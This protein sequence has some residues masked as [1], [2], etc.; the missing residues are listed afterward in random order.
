MRRVYL[1]ILAGCLLGLNANAQQ[2]QE[3]ETIPFQMVEQKPSFNGGDTKAFTEWV[4]SH[5]VYPESEK[6]NGTEGRVTLSITIGADGSIKDVSVIRGTGTE[7]DKEAV[8]VVSSSP[9]WAPGRQK[10]V[11]VNVSFM[12]PVMF[13]LPKPSS[14]NTASSNSESQIKEK[15]QEA[16]HS[17]STNNDWPSW[18]TD[19]ERR[20]TNNSA[21]E[22]ITFSEPLD[23][24]NFLQSRVFKSS[25][26]TTLDISPSGVKANGR[27]I[28]GAVTV[29][30]IQRQQAIMKA[31]SPRTGHTYTFIAYADRNCIVCDDDHTMYFGKK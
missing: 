19:Y 1:F 2:Q 20:G 28:T 18:I 14:T 16:N 17:N 22:V 13:S 11:P 8:R 10:G 4:N 31:T 6:A 30:Y 3:V 15:S 29:T 25:D 24:F 7:L 23:V 26:G 9:K 27:T 12:Y 5:I 21:E